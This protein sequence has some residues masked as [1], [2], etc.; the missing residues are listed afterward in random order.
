MHRLGSPKAATIDMPP[1]PFPYEF[2]KD[3]Y[4]GRICMPGLTSTRMRTAGRRLIKE[5]SDTIWRAISRLFRGARGPRGRPQRRPK[6]NVRG[7]G[8][9][10]LGAAAGPR[11]FPGL[12]R[13]STCKRGASLTCPD[14]HGAGI[15]QASLGPH[16]GWLC[17]SAPSWHED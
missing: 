2:T 15:L 9:G 7:E 5:T 3:F 11:L 13:H 17:G 12:G 8:R 10:A 14:N 6:R 16:L 1:T 4:K